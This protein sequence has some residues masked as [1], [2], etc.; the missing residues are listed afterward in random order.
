MNKKITFPELVDA[1]A[2]IT[3]TSKRTSETFLKELF[4]T[5]TD[6]LARGENVKIKNFGVFKLVEVGERK[7]VNVNTG[8]EMQIPGH[9]K[10]SFS[11][12]KSLADAINT[13]FAS[14]ETVILS[15]DLSDDDLRKLS[16]YDKTEPEI[17]ET[18]FNVEGT[19]TGKKDG[20]VIGEDIIISADSTVDKEDEIVP[21]PFNPNKGQEDVN[22]IGEEEITTDEQKQPEKGANAV[23]EEGGKSDSENEHESEGNDEQDSETSKEEKI[24]RWEEP[25]DENEGAV[26][27][28]DDLDC[29]QCKYYR[30][31]RHYRHRS[32]RRTFA[33]G[34]LCG[35]ITMLLI[36]GIGIYVYLLLTSNNTTI[37]NKHAAEVEALAVDD[38]SEEVDTT[39]V[40]ADSAVV[41]VKE[42][43][44][45]LRYDTISRSRF[46]TSMSRTYYGDYH[47]W[48]YIY[49]ENKDFLGNPNAIP[50]GTVVVI[51]P[52]E[53][54]GIDKNN[55][56]S[57]NAA[58]EKAAEIMKPYER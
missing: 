32:K 3:N 40:V 48:V 57:L 26:D 9:V 21:P 6:A 13:P 14:F 30:Y 16:S 8:E 53:K 44:Q 41:E 35:S 12:D 20:S 54:Y 28:E 10:V 34:F 58:I 23:I 52:A 1:V 49:E 24:Y 42:E 19:E 43:P 33:K 46:L 38:V 29:E 7:S 36:A 45:V 22:D 25:A 39:D 5:I 4:A 11:P 50:P 37:L 55:P 31:S 2:T 56:E 17:A 47:F 51:P 27:K 15:D 18:A